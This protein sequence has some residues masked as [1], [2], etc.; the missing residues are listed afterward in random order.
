[1]LG[2]LAFAL[3]LFVFA[4]QVVALLAPGIEGGSRDV[5]I[6]LTRILSPLCLLILGNAFL[7]TLCYAQ[8]RFRAPALTALVGAAGPPVALLLLRG[9]SAI[10]ALAVGTLIGNAAS[11]LWL[12]L[13]FPERRHLQ[14]SLDLRDPDVR[15]LAKTAIP[16]A[17]GVSMVQVNFIVDRFFAS[18]L[19]AGHIAALYYGM[20]TVTTPVRLVIGPLGRALMPTLSQDA[21]RQEHG[22]IRKLLVTAPMVVAFV[23]VPATTFLVVFRHDLLQL[24]F[25]RQNFDA[26]STRLTAAAVLFFSLGLVSYFLN[27][28][29]TAT[30]FSFQ[31]SMT[32]LKVAAFA[33][34]LNIPLDYLLMQ[35]FGIGGIALATSL[36]V[37]LNTFQLWHRIQKRVG[38]L[39]SLPVLKSVGRTVLAAGLMGLIC[40]LAAL[41]MPEE[42]TTIVHLLY[43]GGA[44]A[45]GSAAYVGVQGVLNRPLVD[46]LVGLFSSRRS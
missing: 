15:R 3:L 14:W 27:P 19:G 23:L 34:L 25:Q 1:V 44:F 33:T 35:R 43:L 5:T 46:R 40:H 31:D 11:L 2:L 22:R 39:E 20:K 36:V 12:W 7:S 10:F 30:F 8:N 32:P 21:A 45:V 28:I 26:E 37:T 24:V 6:L 4:P 29:L 41:W 38:V 13:A 17:L 9:P 42:R 16:R 18:F